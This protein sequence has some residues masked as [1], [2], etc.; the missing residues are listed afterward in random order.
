MLENDRRWERNRK[1]SL[2]IYKR[3]KVAE[4]G[5]YITLNIYE[6]IINTYICNIY[7]NNFL[8]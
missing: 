5:E 1:N 8:R 4:K 6:I 7:T 3:T 2:P